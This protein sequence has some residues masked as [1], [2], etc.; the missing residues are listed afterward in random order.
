M[1]RN[2]RSTAGS[3][4]ESYQQLTVKQRE[5]FCE[6]ARFQPVPGEEVYAILG[7]P[8]GRTFD[9]LFGSPALLRHEMWNGT[10]RGDPKKHPVDY[11][12]NL[13]WHAGRPKRPKAKRMSFQEIAQD[14]NDW[15]FPGEGKHGW[16]HDAVRMTYNRIKKA[17]GK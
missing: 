14:L 8:R 16:T 9:E 11:V 6:L 2:E 10:W 7:V 17:L 4:F 5:R 12:I 15:G 3:V 1:A 13:L